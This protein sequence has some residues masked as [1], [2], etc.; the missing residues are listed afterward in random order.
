MA[1]RAGVY[2]VPVHVEHELT[3][4]ADEYVPVLVPARQRLHVDENTAPSIFEYV[5]GRQ[6][7]HAWVPDVSEYVPF[8]QRE[9]VSES[10][11]M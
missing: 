11:S 4:S 10:L 3:D 7:E 5:P 6:G 9:R 2:V 8:G 1:P